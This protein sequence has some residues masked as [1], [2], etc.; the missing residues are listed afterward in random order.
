MCCAE[1]CLLLKV[2]YT[3]GVKGPMQ[4]V[5]GKGILTIRAD[6]RGGEPHGAVQHRNGTGLVGHSRLWKPQSLS[7]LSHSVTFTVILLNSLFIIVNKKI[8]VCG[9]H[10]IKKTTRE[11][12]V[13]RLFLDC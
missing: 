12:Y 2:T 3:C 7:Q 10:V 4:R 9:V 8:H 5:G 6:Q 1:C 13:V 11:M